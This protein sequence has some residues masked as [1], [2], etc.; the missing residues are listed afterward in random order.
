MRRALAQ[1][2]AN[3]CRRGRARVNTIVDAAIAQL[4]HQERE[5]DVQ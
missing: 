2:G 3:R 5:G 1:A 4:N